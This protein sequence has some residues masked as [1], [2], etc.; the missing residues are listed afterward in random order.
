VNRITSEHITKES[1]GKRRRVTSSLSTDA[2]ESALP[3]HTNIQERKRSA[4]GS[5]ITR[6]IVGAAPTVFTATEIR[7]DMRG[8]KESR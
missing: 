1:T 4:P 3:I 2:K 5:R 6:A 7:S 8:P